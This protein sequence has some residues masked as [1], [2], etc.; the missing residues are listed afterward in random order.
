M[1]SKKFPLCYL[2]EPVSE[3]R[4]ILENPY[5]VD[6]KGGEIITPECLVIENSKILH[7]GGRVDTGSR[8][9]DSKGKF[10]VPG[11]WDM[12]VHVITSAEYAF[13]QFLHHGVTGI[14]DMGSDLTNT[15]EWKF[16]QNPRPRISF[17]GPILDGFIPFP[18]IRLFVETAQDVQI[19]ISSTI[20]AGA[21]LV[22]IHNMLPREAFFT[23]ADR[24]KEEGIPLCGH[25]PFSVTA[26]EAVNAGQKTIE[27]M[28]GIPIAVSKDEKLLRKRLQALKM[29]G[30]ESVELDYLAWKT[31]DEEKFQ[32]LV[33]AFKAAGVFVT[34]TLIAVKSIC[35]DRWDADNP[36]LEKYPNHVRRS[37][38]QHNDIWSE[39]S[40]MDSLIAGAQKYMDVSKEMVCAL[41][42]AGVNLLAGTDSAFLPGPLE[43]M[44][45]FGEGI[46]EELELLVESGLSPFEA[47]KTATTNAADCLGLGDCLGS[48]EPGKLADMVIL[49]N[50]PLE[51]ISNIRNIEAIVLGGKYF[52][53]EALNAL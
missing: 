33:N 43:T 41:N 37:I 53:Q 23:A 16:S 12:H 3:Q 9:I 24:C 20:R 36:L 14:R 29:A 5:V 44:V 19:Q 22:K 11:L 32:Q 40:Q 27:H 6:M 45:L 10:I 50:N 17:A 31:R 49:A 47:L 21:D 18:V 7:M 52:D 48:I 25:V 35:A 1:E 30:T 42:K 51:N 2:D 8:S 34:P 26:F 38:R 46:H 28:Q 15:V 39:D 13:P 4:I